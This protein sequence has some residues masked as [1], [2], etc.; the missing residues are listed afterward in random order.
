MVVL[1]RVDFL[2]VA[3]GKVQ[4]ASQVP[5]TST[6]RTEP[7]IQLFGAPLC[8]FDEINCSMHNELVHMLR[9]FSKACD[10]IA[11]YLGRPKVQ[12]EERIVAR[13]DDAEIVGHFG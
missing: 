11:A 9:F 4:S 1:E 2:Q 12:L 13:A 10:A 8:L 7:S 3:A 5:W 6:H